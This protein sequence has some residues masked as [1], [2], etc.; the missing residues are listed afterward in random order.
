[1][2]IIDGPLVIL[3][4]WEKVVTDF[5]RAQAELLAR[6][7][8]RVY[9]AIPKGATY[10]LVRVTQITDEKMT[11]E[12]LWGVEAIIQVEAY[13]GTKATASGVAR[14]CEGL[15]AARVRGTYADEN[16]VVSGFSGGGM[17]DL[18]DDE[19]EPAKPRFVFTC[20]IF[21][22]PITVDGP[23]PPPPPGG[24]LDGGDAT[25]TATQTVDALDA[26]A[27]DPTRIY[28]GGSA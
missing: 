21:G 7:G 27:G 9:T 25:S 15:L 28:D 14:L 8:D 17:Q 23:I 13:G 16:A 6:I 5:L 19:Y 11:S 12:P 26:F 10:P 3:P 1:M 18:P 20:S 4:N 2:T 22:H 24:D